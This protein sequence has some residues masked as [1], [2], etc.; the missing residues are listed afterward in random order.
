[1]FSANYEKGTFHI[2]G[3]FSAVHFLPSSTKWTGLIFVLDDGKIVFQVHLFISSIVFKVPKKS[4]QCLKL[5]R[6]IAAQESFNDGIFSSFL[7]DET[8]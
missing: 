4:V 7:G 1:M 6:Q 5:H 3:N 8:L 2:V